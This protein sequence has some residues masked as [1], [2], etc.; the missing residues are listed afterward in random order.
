MFKETN[1][2]PYKPFLWCP[3]AFIE[4]LLRTILTISM[5][6]NGVKKNY[7][8]PYKPFLWCLMMFKETNWAPY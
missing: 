6:P 3:M 4:A 1:W 2:A 5:V 8:A 7:W